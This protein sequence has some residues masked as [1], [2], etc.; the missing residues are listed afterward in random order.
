MISVYLTNEA[1][2]LSVFKS[3]Y[4]TDGNEPN[5]SE[6]IVP[7]SWVYLVEPTEDEIMMISRRTKISETIL[8]AALD[9]EETS[10]IDQ[11]GDVSIIVVDTPI[12]VAD[13][14]YPQISHFYT[15]PLSIIFNKD[16]FITA[17][18]K[19]D[20]VVPS[21]M[22]KPMKQFSTAKHNKLTI[23]LLYRNATI[24]VSMLKMLDKESDYIQGKLQEALENAEL[25]ELMN[26]G[27]S[28]V[29][30]STG[31]N[32]DLIVME[33]IRKIE[34]FKQY[35][36]D[37]ALL[38]DAIIENRQAIEMCSI[39]R[40]I[41]NGTMD[42]YAS[43]ISNNVNTIMKTLTVVTI[44]LTVPMIIAAFFGMNVKLPVSE[45]NGFWI[46]VIFSLIVSFGA[47]IFLSRYT[48]KMKYRWGEGRRPFEHQKKKIK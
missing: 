6:R 45:S 31:L 42:T 19:K 23:Q 12:L 32:A 46:A 25:F 44:V 38:D 22:A 33:R 11:D 1:G 15:I 29:Y 35:A 2:E 27:K 26:L 17:S 10:H 14:I 9:E 3:G 48:R 24:F 43:V 7:R 41:L 4:Q 34:D 16:F 5:I 13:S 18:V 37:Y 47:G 8:R 36:D 39:H 21:L 20:Q 40:E 30:L 28:L